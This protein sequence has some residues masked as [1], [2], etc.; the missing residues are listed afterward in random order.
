MNFRVTDLSQGRSIQLTPIQEKRSQMSVS[1]PVVFTKHH[2][3]APLRIDR[4][5]ELPWLPFCLLPATHKIYVHK[6]FVHIHLTSDLYTE[7]GQQGFREG[8]FLAVCVIWC[9]SAIG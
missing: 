4:A 3:T 7:V 2:S 1:R 9:R 6:T 5:V 8:S